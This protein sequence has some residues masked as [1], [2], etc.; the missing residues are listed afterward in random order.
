[1]VLSRVEVTFVNLHN[2]PPSTKPSVRR[3]FKQLHGPVD[4]AL[5]NI[6]VRSPSLFG[7][8]Q[9]RSD[10]RDLITPHHPCNEP[11]NPDVFNAHQRR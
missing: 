5:N 1:M 3:L 10:A 8:A 11:K 2:D 4:D 7:D 6:F 9:S